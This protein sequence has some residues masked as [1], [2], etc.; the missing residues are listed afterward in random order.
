MAF[1]ILVAGGE[2]PGSNSTQLNRP[3]KVCVDTNENIYV[4]D[5]DNDRIQRFYSGSSIGQTIA[6]HFLGELFGLGI[7]LQGNIYVSEYDKSRVTKWMINATEGISVAGNETDGVSSSQ[8]NVPTDFQSRESLY[9]QMVIDKFIRYC[10]CRY[11]W[12]IR[13]Q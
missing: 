6:G 5:N 13:I 3:I 4:T 1:G 8:L 2:G 12:N 7:D 9:Y 11:M 10:C